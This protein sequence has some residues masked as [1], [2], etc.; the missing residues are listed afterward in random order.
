MLRA[1][2][3]EAVPFLRSQGASIVVIGAPFPFKNLKFDF[4][5]NKCL[6]LGGIPSIRLG[7]R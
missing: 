7:R 5:N 3:N 4:Y 1:D 6:Y 2:S